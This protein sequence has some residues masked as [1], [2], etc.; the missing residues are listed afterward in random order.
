M[1]EF[2]E[3]VLGQTTQRG[4]LAI[5]LEEKMDVSIMSW[6]MLDFALITY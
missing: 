6:L 2:K 5:A 3:Q 4:M 1:E